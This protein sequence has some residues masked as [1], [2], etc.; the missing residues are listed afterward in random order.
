MDGE[1]KNL[2]MVITVV[3][4][5]VHSDVVLIMIFQRRLQ[6]IVVVGI[7]N[8]YVVKMVSLLKLMPLDLIVHVLNKNSDVVQMDKHQK[9]INSIL[10]VESQNSDVAQMD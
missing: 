9:K 2:L 4:K 7:L 5:K 8:S 3:A 1:L 6:E 10:V